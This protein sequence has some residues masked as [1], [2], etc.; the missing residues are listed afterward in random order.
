[1]SNAREGF[2]VDFTGYKDRQSARVPEGDY[3]VRISDAE[4]TEIKS[5]DNAGKPMVNLYYE[6]AQGSSTG[7]MLVD[8]L[9][10]TEKALWRVAAFLRA[11]GLKVEKKQLQIPFKLIMGRTFVVTVKDG[12]PYNGNVKSEVTSYASAAGFTVESSSATQPQAEAGT[13]TSD[14][15]ADEPAWEEPKA[16]LSLVQNGA[17]EI[18]I[19]ASIQL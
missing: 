14:Q 2:V 6:I 9:P 1:M 13:D 10:I 5:G 19:P 11:I 17:G 16:Q 4:V 7:Q 18:S 12:E 15:T 3:L 8:R